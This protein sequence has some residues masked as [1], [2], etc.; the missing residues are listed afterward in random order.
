VDVLAIEQAAENLSSVFGVLLLLLFIL[1]IAK[2]NH[3]FQLPPVSSIN[4]VSLKHLISGFLTYLSLAFLILPFIQLLIAFYYSGS[5]REIQN[6]SPVLKGWMQLAMLVA[7]FFA[8]FIYC[9]LIHAKVRDYIFW[10]DKKKNIE[11][12]LKSFGMGLIAWAVSYPCVLFANLVTRYISDWI[13]GKTSFEQ[14]AVKHLKMTL[15]HPVLFG[16]M[17]TA[18]ILLVPFMEELLFRGLFQNVIK[19]YLGRGWS[20]FVTAALFSVVHYAASQSTG[21]FQLILSL[22]VLAYFLSFIY[23]REKTLWAPIGLHMAFNGFN[24]LMIILFKSE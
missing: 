10:G 3:F 24:V 7:L 21:N 16:L 2:R 4:P 1:W 15:S 8:L 5:I 12:F 23:E 17:V 18:I 9:C 20:I 13:W 19:K 22:F 14:V 6:L 11:T